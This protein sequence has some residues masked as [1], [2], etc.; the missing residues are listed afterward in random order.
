MRTNFGKILRWLPALV[1]ML[2]IFIFS[3]QPGGGSGALSKLVM[4][5]LAKFGIDFPAWFGDDAV[6]VLR[7]CAH[8]S[9]YFIL[10]FFLQ[11][12][13]RTTWKWHTAR[14]FALAGTIIYAASDEFHQLFIPGRV[15][16][17]LDV[18]IDSSGAFACFLF[19]SLFFWLRNK[20]VQHPS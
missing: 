8:F 2:I 16:D 12:A 7:K 1:W 6:W 11:F 14:W 3:N 19:L 10:F 4:A 13:F 9:I 20:K 17:I 15:G 18:A 5:W